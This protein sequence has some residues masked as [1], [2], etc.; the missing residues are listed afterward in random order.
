V[1]IGFWMARRFGGS[2]LLPYIMSQMGGALCASAL[3]WM[4]FAGHPTLGRTMPH[5]SAWQS[6]V[7]EMVLTA[8]LMFVILSVSAG[9]KE[10]GMVA[11]IAVGG[12]IA[13]E[14]MFAGPISGASMN[15]ARSIAPAVVTMNFANLWV[16]L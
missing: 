2:M 6:F 9:S 3:M 7:L 16:Y 10:R 14:A 15:P 12:V 8:I 11:G 1:T 5:G 13:F 4:M